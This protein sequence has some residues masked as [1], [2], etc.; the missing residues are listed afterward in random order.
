MGRDLFR[1]SDELIGILLLMTCSVSCFLSK[2]PL[3]PEAK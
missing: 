3:C 2:K 1:V